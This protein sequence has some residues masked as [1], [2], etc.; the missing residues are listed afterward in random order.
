MFYNVTR[1]VAIQTIKV[2]PNK[3]SIFSCFIDFPVNVVFKLEAIYK[4]LLLNNFPLKSVAEL[5]IYLAG[6][7]LRVFMCIYLHLAELKGM[8]QVE[9]CL[10][11]DPR[12]FE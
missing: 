10:T 11:R 1:S 4:K 12:P 8:R 2:L 9:L 3:A 6:V 7:D 5:D